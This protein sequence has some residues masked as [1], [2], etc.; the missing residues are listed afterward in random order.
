MTSSENL[1]KL[2][3]SSVEPQLQ[4]TVYT[5]Y[6]GKLIVAPQSN[7]IPISSASD[8]DC[9]S[10]EHGGEF[11]KQDKD[12]VYI[13][14][15]R[16]NLVHPDLS[17]L[18]ENIIEN[19][20]SAYE[21]FWNGNF[22][23]CLERRT[24]P[25][26]GHT[27]LTPSQLFH[28]LQNSHLISNP[29]VCF[30]CDKV[31]TKGRTEHMKIIH[32]LSY[33]DFTCEVCYE[34]FMNETEKDVHRLQHISTEKCK[35]C[36]AS[37]P[38]GFLLREHLQQC[39]Y[40]KKH[41]ICIICGCHFTSS[42]ILQLHSLRHNRNTCDLCGLKLSEDASIKS[43]YHEVTLVKHLRSVHNG[44]EIQNILTG[45]KKQDEEE[46]ILDKL[47][48]TQIESNISELKGMASAST[49]DTCV[50]SKENAVE[51]S[52]PSLNNDT[53]NFK[54]TSTSVSL[55]TIFRCSECSKKFDS[56]KKL[57][58]HA[59]DH[60]TPFFCD[61]C[62]MSF[63]HRRG[64]KKHMRCHGIQVKPGLI[65]Y[66][67]M[68]CSVNCS[69]LSGLRTHILTHTEHKPHLCD[70]CG[71]TFRRLQTL[72]M[73]EITV[74][75]AKAS[76]MCHQCG[77]SSTSR[78]SLLRHIQ[79]VHAGIR[80]FICGLCGTRF[81]Q[82][83]DLRRH[84]KSVHK[85]DF[86]PLQC[87]LKKSNSQIHVIPSAESIN[88][89][90]PLVALLKSAVREEESKLEVFSNREK[91]ST[92][93]C[94]K[95]LGCSRPE[96]SSDGLSLNILGDVASKAIPL[97]QIKPCS[98]ESVQQNSNAKL[99][100]NPELFCEGCHYK[101]KDLAE[102]SSHSSMCQLGKSH[103]AAT[104]QKCIDSAFSS[105]P[106]IVYSVEPLQGSATSP[107]NLSVFSSENAIPPP[108]SDLPSIS[109]DGFVCSIL[110]SLNVESNLSPSAPLSV[111]N[112]VNTFICSNGEGA[113]NITVCSG[114][115][116][117]EGD[118]ILLSQNDSTR[119]FNI[120]SVGSLDQSQL[121]F[122]G[123]ISTM[124]EEYVSKEAKDE[125][126]HYFNHS[127]GSFLT[128]SYHSSGDVQSEVIIKESSSNLPFPDGKNKQKLCSPFSNSNHLISS[129]DTIDVSNQD[130]MNLLAHVESVQSVSFSEP[131][132][133]KVHKIL[134]NNL[135]AK[136]FDKVGKKSKNKAIVNTSQKTSMKLEK[137]NTTDICQSYITLSVQNSSEEQEK[138]NK[139]SHSE[140][141]NTS[142]LTCPE[143]GKKLASASNFKRH[144]EVHFG[145][146]PHECLYCGKC[147]RYKCNLTVHIRSHTGDRPYECPV[148]SKKFRYQTEFKEHKQ[149]HETSKLFSCL[150]CGQRF[151]RQ[152]D[153]KRHSLSHSEMNKPTCT[154]CQKTFSRIDYLNI[155]LRSHKKHDEIGTVK[156]K[157]FSQPKK[158]TRANKIIG[159][160]CKDNLM[161]KEN[162][163]KK[164]I[165]PNGSRKSRSDLC[166]G[167]MVCVSD[168]SEDLISLAFQAAEDG[169][170]FMFAEEN[171]T[172]PKENK[173]ETEGSSYFKENVVD[174][175][176]LE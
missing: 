174:I 101:S 176:V 18:E 24:C 143:C 87:L 156:D 57:M 27:F 48:M 128:N 131:D 88:P 54:N 25:K 148:C 89:T 73:H 46:E 68:Q 125:T 132:P 150:D 15:F 52:N 23:V 67:C 47:F 75:N 7:Q 85:L 82:N 149:I 70:K 120:L 91:K 153:L 53:K 165:I 64:F 113:S 78:K 99:Q 173:T 175:K 79:C 166:F 118:S 45:L 22:E 98:S 60:Q 62:K 121:D 171:T 142:S 1:S 158:K 108:D 95:Q 114:N 162:S 36:S 20:S 119:I 112:F 59:L 154:I 8:N 129:D 109:S 170:E 133:I 83:Q 97:Q 10:S 44:Q 33:P 42:H 71:L 32:H 19:I 105:K 155:H 111:P 160:S 14:I 28:H 34:V 102:F 38:C 139:T 13:E 11:N 63:Q 21:A 124:Q 127:I 134:Q 5:F 100:G 104:Q 35:W 76:H 145:G 3:S 74:H 172:R 122:L 110:P 144:L 147:F 80:R 56:K 152:R 141:L 146:K 168:K 69:T 126:G 16:E 151:A 51:I 41:L 130:S 29:E 115:Q 49:I 107:Q 103:C 161:P 17:K 31:F 26:C 50:P 4:E 106:A 92:S 157:C 136:E 86:P 84:L 169:V 43:D 39:L 30:V 167:K 66:K 77:S 137:S 90:D 65:R 55:D 94:E 96:T 72:R 9:I 159:E 37:F 135:P 117:S 163:G 6:D 138:T 12:E 164:I 2:I 40:Q 58:V 123:P 93:Y 61:I 140:I 116:Y 81:L